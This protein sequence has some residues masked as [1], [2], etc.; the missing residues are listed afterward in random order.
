VTLFG[1][2]R[3]FTRYLPSLNAN[4]SRVF[5]SCSAH[6]QNLSHLRQLRSR[7]SIFKIILAACRSSREKQTPSCHPQRSRRFSPASARYL[8]KYQPRSLIPSNDHQPAIPH[9]QSHTAPN[10]HTA[11][12]TLA[13]LTKSGARWPATTTTCSGR[14]HK[15]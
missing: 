7:V 8:N 14:L 5:P 2:R 12:R 6:Q 3:G 11:I 13:A 15:Q 9:P 4:P 10:F 1:R